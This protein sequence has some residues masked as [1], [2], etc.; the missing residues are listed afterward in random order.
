MLG[1]G[2]VLVLMAVPV[3]VLMALLVG[4]RRCRAAAQGPTS[5]R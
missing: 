1:A 4:R 2:A 3:A 5:P